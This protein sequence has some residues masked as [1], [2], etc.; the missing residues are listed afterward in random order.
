MNPLGVLCAR[1][2][3][4]PCDGPTP[5]IAVDADK[6]IQHVMMEV[7]DTDEPIGVIEDGKIIGQISKD[8]ILA[9]ILN[10]RS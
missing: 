9:K 5:S 7:G 3:V 6:D 8:R 10:P 2:L 1:N 4:E